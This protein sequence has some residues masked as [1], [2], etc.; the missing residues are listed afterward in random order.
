MDKNAETHVS[1]MILQRRTLQ[2]QLPSSFLSLFRE[3]GLLSQ[4]GLT[5]HHNC[6]AIFIFERSKCC[7][8]CVV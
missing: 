6:I 2:R 1:E 7:N 8:L 5:G 3:K 4:V